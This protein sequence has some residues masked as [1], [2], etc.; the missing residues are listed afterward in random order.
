MCMW[1]L[2]GFCQKFVPNIF[3]KVGPTVKIWGHLPSF[4]DLCL[5]C[6]PGE[7]RH[8]PIFVGN[9]PLCVVMCCCRCWAAI[10]W[11]HLPVISL[12]VVGKRVN[13]DP[14]PEG[15]CGTLW[16]LKV[17]PSCSQSDWLQSTFRDP[18]EVFY[19]E[20]K[21]RRL[22]MCVWCGIGDRRGGQWDTSCILS[23]GAGFH[24][25]LGHYWKS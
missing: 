6:W 20:R 15:D 13:H 21:L 23:G 7:L 2:K 18:Q 12:W 4:P 1:L 5:P 22:S 25:V 16:E 3:K 19:S 10:K 17:F 9:P 24:H 11:C 14:V 8:L